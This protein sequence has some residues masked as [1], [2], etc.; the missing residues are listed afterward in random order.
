MSKIT[1][2]VPIRVRY[3]ECDPQNVAHHS[4]FVVWFEIARTELLRK[5]GVAYRTLEERGVYFVV[6]EL[7]MKLKRPVRY[8]DA[9]TVR[10]TESRRTHVRIDHTYEVLLDGQTCATGTSTIACVNR[11]GRPMA[12]PE[13][14]LG[15]G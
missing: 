9:I 8:D 3:R 13:G 10:V 14:A 15:T 7:S 2:D 6:T 4:A 5:F 1:T 11:S 12:I